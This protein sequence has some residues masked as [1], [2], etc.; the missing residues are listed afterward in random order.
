[1]ASS[2]YFLVAKCMFAV[3]AM[4]VTA[5]VNVAP[6]SAAYPERSMDMS[7]FASMES[8]DDAVYVVPPP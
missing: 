7:S 8:G 6:E 5:P 4:P 1:M 3:G 2:T